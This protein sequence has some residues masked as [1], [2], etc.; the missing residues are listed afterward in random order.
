VDTFDADAAAGE[1]LRSVSASRVPLTTDVLASLA[2]EHAALAVLSVTQASPSTNGE[3]LAALAEDSAAWPHMSALVADHQTAG[4]G[5]AGR[6]WHTPQGAAL[7][8]SYVLRPRLPRERWGLIPLVVG[9]AAVRTMRAEGVD[10]S[11]KWPNDVVVS[12]GTYA[13]GADGEGEAE[14]AGWG[15]L[16]KLAGI[17][18]EVSGDAVVAGI[19]INVSQEASELPVAH[20]TSMATVGARRLDRV[21]LLESLSK[22]VAI[23]VGRAEADPEGFLADLAGVTCTLG[24][25]VVVERPG[26]PPM[27]GMAE[28]IG[29]DGSLTVRTAAG[30]VIAVTAGDVRLRAAPSQ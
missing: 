25:Q 13:D 26:S 8:V 5:R 2:G 14:I 28:A 3:V 4:R 9:L 6:E 18:C 30:E 20:A 11:L 7:T 12:C 21:A 27:T 16:R 22:Q 23:E 19:G 10:A 15:P 1:F 24:R 17:L 29:A